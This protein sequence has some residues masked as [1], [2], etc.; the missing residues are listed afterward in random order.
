MALIRSPAFLRDVSVTGSVADLRIVWQQSQPYRWRIMLA[1]AAMTLGMFSVI[2]QE[3]GQGLPPPPKITYITSWRADRSI[4]EIRRTNIA[5]QKR[6]EQLAAEQAK[7][8][9]E[10]RNIYK[11]IGS[12]SGMDV[13][14]IEKK[15]AAERAAEAA[16][17]A[18]P[19]E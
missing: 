19:G 12:M 14:A 4:E 6:K 13:E 18:K 10:V 7:R 11:K 16:K 2:W 9:E 3:G 1:S 5:N 17:A 8:E 15:A